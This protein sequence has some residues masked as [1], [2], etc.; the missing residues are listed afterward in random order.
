ME[1][2]S[3]AVRTKSC[4]DELARLKIEFD[5]WRAGREVGQR[6][7]LQLWASAVA[8]AVEHGAYRV[9][10][11]LHLDYAV[12]RRRAA[13]APANAPANPVTPRFVELFAP[14]GPVTSARTSQPACVIE[15]V[16]A[17]GARMRVEFHSDALAGLPAMCSAFWAA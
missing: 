7:P 1:A 5:Q 8:A 15:M 4:S 16:N 17:R 14:A 12:L 9:A 2:T 3:K 10:A 11:E 6:I 13:A